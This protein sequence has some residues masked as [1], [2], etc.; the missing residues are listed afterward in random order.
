MKLIIN[1]IMKLIYISYKLLGLLFLE[2][3]DLC[4]RS[5]VATDGS[6][7]HNSVEHEG[8]DDTGNSRHYNINSNSISQWSCEQKR[9]TYI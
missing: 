7:Q 8:T 1:I 9:Q 6:D 4:L 2:P 3:L 5:S